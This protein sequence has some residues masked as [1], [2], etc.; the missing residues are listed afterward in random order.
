MSGARVQF[1]SRIGFI[2]AAAGSA[3]GIGNLVGFPAGAASRVCIFFN[4]RYFRFC[5]L[6]T[7][8]AYEMS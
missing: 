5:H 7:G 6:F 8:N 4:V 3:V 1:G 2:L